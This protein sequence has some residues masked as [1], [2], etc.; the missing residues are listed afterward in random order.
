MGCMDVV[1]S[2]NRKHTFSCIYT[3]EV[4][5]RLWLRPIILGRDFQL[6]KFNAHRLVVLLCPF[7]LLWRVELFLTPRHYLIFERQALILPPTVASDR[8]GEWQA[9]SH[10]GRGNNS[11]GCWVCAW[12]KAENVI[13]LAHVI[14]FW[15]AERINVTCILLILVFYKVKLLT[16][17][18]WCNC[19][20]E[21][22]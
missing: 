1:L 6:F 3:G 14:T 16:V 4:L 11:A 20:K 21:D 13:Y 9:G 7:I 22:I 12:L 8:R 15:I 5:S 17:I 19:S 10:R 2:K 18:I